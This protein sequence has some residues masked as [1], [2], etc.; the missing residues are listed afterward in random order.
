MNLTLRARGCKASESAVG[1]MGVQFI[2][3]QDIGRLE[4]AV[5]H[6]WSTHFVQIP[7]NYDHIALT[8]LISH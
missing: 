2:V 8:S 4:V 5:D 6:R 7:G 3:Q 1:N